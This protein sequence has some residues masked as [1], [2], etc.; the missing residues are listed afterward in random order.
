MKRVRRTLAMTETVER[1]LVVSPRNHTGGDCPSCTPGAGWLTLE[2]AA[3]IAGRPPAS[4]LD[5]AASGELHSMCGPGGVRLIC[6]ISLSL[7]ILKGD[8][9][10]ETHIS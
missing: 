6:A 5:L 10:N 4:L 2:E 1:L 7:K 8:K 3:R 9:E